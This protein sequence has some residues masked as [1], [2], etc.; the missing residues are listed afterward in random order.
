MDRDLTGKASHHQPVQYQGEIKARNIS[1]KALKSL[2][3]SECTDL[4]H[5]SFII[6]H[7]SFIIW[8]QVTFH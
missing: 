3:I 2:C 6:Y 5:L 4:Y 7:L 1:Q 8:Q